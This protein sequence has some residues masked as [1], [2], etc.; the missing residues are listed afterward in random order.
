LISS[1]TEQQ[2]L[3][4]QLLVIEVVVSGG[5]R[6][7]WNIQAQRLRPFALFF[8]Q[9]ALQ[10]NGTQYLQFFEGFRKLGFSPLIIIW[11]KFSGEMMT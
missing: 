8:N 6:N 11:V 7:G 3:P 4:I 10:C 2:D 5:G 9:T 1:T